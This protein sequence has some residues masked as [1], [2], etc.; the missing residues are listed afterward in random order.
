M[1]RVPSDLVLLTLRQ[2]GVD[3]KP[4]SLR[5]WTRRGLISRTEDGY[6]LTEVLGYAERPEPTERGPGGR[7][8]SRVST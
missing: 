4:A 5:N 1:R 3:L 6:D 2:S 8:R 7:Y